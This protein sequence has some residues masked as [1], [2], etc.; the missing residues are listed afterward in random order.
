[1]AKVHR[2]VFC[3][4]VCVCVCVYVWIDYIAAPGSQE[5]D[6]HN[7]QSVIDSL[8]LDYLQISLSHI[9]GR[10]LPDYS[11]SP[12]TGDGH[13]TTALFADISAI[14]HCEDESKSSDSIQLY[15]EEL[16]LNG[17]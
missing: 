15:P 16:K 5:D 8:A 17:F 2:D 1:M 9:T 10:Q 7:I 12:F 14:N 4:C 11:P 13:L 6:I 3:N